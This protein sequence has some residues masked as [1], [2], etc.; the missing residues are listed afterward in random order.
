MA[1]TAIHGWYWRN[2]GDTGVTTTLRTP[3]FYRELF[4][5]SSE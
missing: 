3:A 2:N 1:F 4:Q 5:P